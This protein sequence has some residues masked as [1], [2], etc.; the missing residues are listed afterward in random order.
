[1]GPIRRTH[2]STVRSLIARNRLGVPVTVVVSIDV[3]PPR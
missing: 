1:M 2:S 3:E